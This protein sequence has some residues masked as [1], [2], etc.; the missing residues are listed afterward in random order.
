MR[1]I[2]PS[3]SEGGG[4]QTNESSLPLFIGCPCRDKELVFPWETTTLESPAVLREQADLADRGIV[5]EHDAEDHVAP[6][7]DFVHN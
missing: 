7:L 6:R 3:G 1:E 4:T 2:R 5:G